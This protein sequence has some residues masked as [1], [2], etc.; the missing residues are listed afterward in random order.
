MDLQKVVDTNPAPFLLEEGDIEKVFSHKSLFGL[1]AH[2]Q[3]AE[4]EPRD[5]DR[6]ERFFIK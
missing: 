4:E 1:P 2:I 3:I 6:Y 5:W